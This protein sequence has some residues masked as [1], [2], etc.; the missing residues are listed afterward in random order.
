MTRVLIFGTG[1]VGSVYGY[2]LDKAGAHVTTVCRSNY[3]AVREK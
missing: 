1:G 3:I 2:I